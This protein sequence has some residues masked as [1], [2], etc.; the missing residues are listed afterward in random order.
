M[1][2]SKKTMPVGM[3]LVTSVMLTALASDALAAGSI[4]LNIA[5]A[6]SRRPVGEATITV[7]S[8]DGERREIP[9]D[10]TGS[11]LIEDLAAGLYEIQVTHPGYLM[12]RQPSVRVVDEKTTP[13]DTELSVVRENFEEMLVMATPVRLDLLSSVSAGEK[14]REALRSAAGGGADVLRSLDGLPGLFSDGEYSSYTVRGNGPRDNLILV[15]GIP[16][17][18]VVHFSDA[19]GEQEDVD[20][21]GRYSVFAPNI[22]ARAKFEPGGWKPAYGGLAGSLLQLDVAEGNQDT[23]SA[24]VRFDVAGLEV[25]YD[26]PTY[27]LDNTSV[28]FSARSLNFTSLFET[29]GIDDVGEPSLT[30]IIVKTSTRL[31]DDKIN[32]LVLHSSEDYVR[33][34]KHAIASDETNVGDYAD[35]SLA[36]ISRTN[37]L[38]ALSWEKLLANDGQ[39]DQRL[40]YRNY[41]EDSVR[42]EAYPDLTPIGTPPSQVFAREEILLSTH[43]EKET[44]YRLDYSM[45]NG[46]G[47]FSTG[48]RVTQLDLDLTL[49]LLDDWVRY[50][51]TYKDYRPDPSQNFIVWTPE[52]TNNRF[53]ASATNYTLYGDQQFTAG[54]WEFRAGVRYDRDNFSEEDI[55]SPRF[56]ATWLAGSSLR[57]TATAGRYH[58]SPTATERAM[59]AGNALLVNELVDQA[60]VGFAYS[61]SEHVEFFVEP[62][63]QQLSNLIVEQDGTS[64]ASAN[65]GE[66]RAFGVDTAITRSFDNGWSADFTYSYNDSQVKDSA[67]SDYYDADFGRPHSMSIGG[68]WE[69]NERWKVSTRWKFASGTPRDTHVVHD[70]VLGDG[71]P[72]RY[73]RETVAFNTGR[74]DSYSALNFRVDYRRAFGRTNVIAFLDVINALGSTNPSNTRFNERSGQDVDEDGSAVPLVGLRL[75]W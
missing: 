48:L 3:P 60:S 37:A 7:I 47:Q 73:S 63:Y 68:I 75:E 29:I 46:I 45:T 2:R 44:G 21:G 25:G 55:W 30:D 43:A 52:N 41:D 23:P 49:D 33:E 36:D 53:E 74:Y 15:D 64:R 24:T 38:Y 70:N 22:I 34:I 35:V 31:S 10:D 20:S 65:T 69:I 4:R 51:Y 57:V 18:D 6:D 71:Q 42:G 56:G 62:Y 66:G 67:D 50:T 72:L 11:V 12:N 8:R 13:I 40:Y 28:L 1:T 16:F 14:D 61:F 54:S 5:D 9:A 32:L 59:D 27:T 58:Q 17:A 26:G 39:L 19:F